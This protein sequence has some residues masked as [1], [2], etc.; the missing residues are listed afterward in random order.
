MIKGVLIRNTQRLRHLPM[1]VNS[2]QLF[3]RLRLGLVPAPLHSG[4][5]AQ[6]DL[7]EA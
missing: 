5:I 1:P 4:G 7:F 3:R 2:G 6:E